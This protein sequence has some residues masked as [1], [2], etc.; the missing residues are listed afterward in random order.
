MSVVDDEAILFSSLIGMMMMM[1]RMMT[2]RDHVV[3][4]LVWCGKLPCANGCIGRE[5][6][7]CLLLHW[8]FVVGNSCDYEISWGVFYRYSHF[9]GRPYFNTAV[10]AQGSRVDF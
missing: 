2:G 6:W 1:M 4:I 10:S 9:A 7:R 5:L 3:G 8:H